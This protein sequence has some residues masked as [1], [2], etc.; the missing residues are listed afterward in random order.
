MTKLSLCND[1][2]IW[3]AFYTNVIDS[4]LNLIFAGKKKKNLSQRLY[5][6]TSQNIYLLVC[7]FGL[8]TIPLSVGTH[9]NTGQY[10]HDI[11]QL[12]VAGWLSY[13]LLQY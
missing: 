5:N 13:G 6:M 11:S 3:R 9:D 8:S 4:C 1:I 2:Y 12:M 10:P 7:L